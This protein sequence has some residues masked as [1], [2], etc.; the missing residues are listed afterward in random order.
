MWLSSK[1]GVVG[2]FLSCPRKKILATKQLFQEAVGYCC[3]LE[4]GLIRA[5]GASDESVVCSDKSLD[6]Q[7]PEKK[8]G[9]KMN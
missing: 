4:V 5:L 8:I 2:H 6:H 7:V 3:W 9:K 1:V